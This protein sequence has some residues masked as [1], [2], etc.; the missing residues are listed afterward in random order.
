MQLITELSAWRRYADEGRRAGRLIGLVATMGALHA[1]HASLFRAAR[2]HGDV[3]LATLFVNPRQFNDAADLAAYPRSPESDRELAEANGVDCLVTPSLAEMWPTYPAPTPT[4]VSVRRLSEV[5]EGAGRPGHFDGVASVVA[6][7]F[8]LTGPCRAYF[9]EK[10]LQ[11]LAVVRQMARD[12]A[13]DV[14][15]VSCP[16]VRD[17]DGLALSSRNVLLSAAGRR[18]ARALS[19]ALRA[20]AQRSA[21]ASEQRA[22]LSR[23][24]GA[25]DLK[26]D[27]AEVVDPVTFAPCTD[28]DAGVRRAMVAAWVDGTRLIDNGPVTVTRKVH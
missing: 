21:P 4:T 12:L 6:K 26:L 22:T 28:G 23:V 3:V 9:G 5:L 11:Q 8:A 2:D 16:I 15:I 13:F 19:Q 24:L 10:D 1:G 7:L 25:A 20:V 18:R 17:E 14:D 27:Y